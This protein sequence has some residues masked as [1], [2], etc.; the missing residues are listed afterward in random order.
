M[1]QS[2]ELEATFRP[3]RN[4]PDRRASEIERVYT[5]TEA[6]A[7]LRIGESTVRLLIATGRLESF[8]PYTRCRRITES[9]LARFIA[10]A[11]SDPEMTKGGAE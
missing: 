11:S 6:A 4:F 2:A 5:T 8:Q 1:S 10:R 9:Q 7:H 3:I